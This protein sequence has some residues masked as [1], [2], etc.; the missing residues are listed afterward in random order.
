MPVWST[1]PSAFRVNYGF[2]IEQL[3]IGKEFY[4]RAGLYFSESSQ[5]LGPGQYAN[6]VLGTPQ[7]TWRTLD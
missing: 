2:I 7:I 6:S 3:P 1:L 4:F 5:N